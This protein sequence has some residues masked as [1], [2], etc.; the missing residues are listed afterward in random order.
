MPDRPEPKYVKELNPGE[1][2]ESVFAVIDK[3]SR[4][5]RAGKAFLSLKLSDKTGSIDAVAW[6]NAEALALKFEKGDVIGVRAEVGSYQNANQL[7]I[8]ALK[9]IEDPSEYMGRFMPVADRDVDVMA[10]E[11]RAL[12]EGV[13][14]P[15]LREL[16]IGFFDDEEFMARFKASSAA[17]GMHHVFAGG[18]V[19]HTLKVA[20]LCEQIYREY[21]ATDPAIAKL[22]DRDL[23]IAGAIVHDIGKMDELSASPGFDY[24]FEGRLVGHISLGLMTVKERI[25]RIDGF[26]SDAA[27]LLMHMLLSH[28]G[29]NEYGSPKRP[30]C[31]EAF[32][33]HYADNLDAKMQGLMEFMEK[34]A[35]EGEFTGFHRLYDRYFY[36]GRPEME[37]Q[38]EEQG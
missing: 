4:T 14:H 12:A 20:R 26:P 9:K 13:S 35:Q 8:T 31:L 11:L 25:D 6:D 34:D 1:R 3:Q 29:E 33:L 5:T 17:K 15:K 30:K 28:H 23:L 10:A 2:V 27:V 16:L 18:L 38:G 7:T 32:I 36:K 21:E 22:I 37:A 19:Q 24:T